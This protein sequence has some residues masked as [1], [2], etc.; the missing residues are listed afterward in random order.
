VAGVLLIAVALAAAPSVPVVESYVGGSAVHGQVVGDRYF[1]DPKHGRPPVEVSESTWRAV[2]WLERVW[3]F[4]AFVPGFLGL[5]LIGYGKGPNAEPPATPPAEV[6]PRVLWACLVSA[7]IV[8][9]GTW[10]FWVAVRVPWATMLAG[11]VLLCTSA[12]AVG[13]FFSQSA[14]QQAA[15]DTDSAPDAARKQAFRE[16]SPN[17]ARRV[18]ELRRSLR[19]PSD[20]WEHKRVCVD[21]WPLLRRRQT[22]TGVAQRRRRYDG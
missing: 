12:V 8:M 11:W 15:G 3:P 20:G 2:Y 13:W 16:A 22:G 19:V 21:G 5:F 1:V 18:A 9:A 7:W 4:S 6:P 14:R 17:R 10:L